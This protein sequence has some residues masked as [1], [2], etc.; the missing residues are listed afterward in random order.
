MTWFALI[1]VPGLENWWITAFHGAYS[2]VVSAG[3]SVEWEQQ[4]W[5]SGRSGL[6]FIEVTHL[7]P[8]SHRIT[9]E[10]QPSLFPS[11]HSTNRHQ[12]QPSLSLLHLFLPVFLHNKRLFDCLQSK[13]VSPSL[14]LSFV[15]FWTRPKNYLLGPLPASL[16]LD[17]LK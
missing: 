15:P 17:Q 2:P 9:R 1:Q 5:H 11:C 3:R 4:S 7:G 8:G 10:H 12:K 16:H 6:L 14:L 13:G